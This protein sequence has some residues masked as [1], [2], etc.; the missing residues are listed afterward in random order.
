MVPVG[1]LDKE[2][3][4]GAPDGLGVTLPVLGAS[5]DLEEV[6]EQHDIDSVLIAFSTAPHAVMLDLVRRCWARGVDVSVVPRLFEVEGRRLDVQHVGALP[7]ISL[8]TSNPVGTSFAVKY[9]LDRA[10][11][12]ILL[13][14]LAPLFLLVAAGILLTSGRPI[15]FRQHRIGRDGLGFELLK[16]RTMRG[17]PEV[18]GEADADWAKVILSGTGIDPAEA[19]ASPRADRC[20]PLGRFLRRY[21]LDELPQLWNVLRG[22]MSLIGPRPE[23]AHYVERFTGTIERYPDRHRVKPGLTGWAQVH[24]LRGDTSLADRIEWDNFYIENWSPWLDVRIL[25]K[26]VPAILARRS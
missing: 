17:A 2:P 24:G 19:L 12:A 6:I 8:R 15:L 13:V 10:V 23:R 22:D 3:L 11:A 16:F 7:L 20:T 18:D 4:D 14:L 1:F 5:W 21:S 25:A 9:A 26:T